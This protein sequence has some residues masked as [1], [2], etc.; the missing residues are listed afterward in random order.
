MISQELCSLIGVHR[1]IGSDPVRPVI[2]LVPELL[3][4]QSLPPISLTQRMRQVRVQPLN[5]VQVFDSFA[6]WCEV[7]D[8]DF[9]AVKLDE[10]P[11]L[12]DTRLSVC[13]GG[14]VVPPGTG[15]RAVE[16]HTERESLVMRA[17]VDSRSR[18]IDSMDRQ[19]CP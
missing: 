19:A 18:P 14:E 12:P 1:Q 17:G 5:E 15:C 9:I 7:I 3:L 8:D 10:T 6:V 13:P 11:G 2:G 4:R 16:F